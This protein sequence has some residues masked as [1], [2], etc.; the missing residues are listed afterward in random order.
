MRI[1]A[2]KFKKR[3][4]YSVPG[5]TTRPTTDFMR[6]VIFSVVQDFTG[7]RILD[8]F[9]GTGALAFEALS[10]GAEYA[11]LVEMAQPAISTIVRNMEYLRCGD[12]IHIHR[13][14][15]A[16]FLS[17][18]DLKFD[19]VFMDPPYD[20]KL[21]NQALELVFANQIILPGGHVIVEHSAQ[22]KIHP[23]FHDYIIYEKKSK[24][25][26]VT[27]LKAAEEKEDSNE[28]I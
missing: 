20:K 13:Q 9:A 19:S 8:L 15:V 25:S 28:D 12:S 11:D 26:M 17:K 7:Q 6:E 10:R 5:V 2:G 14:K 3:S 23:E 4:L 27:I 1:I 22:E 18:T 16:T 21:V 24:L